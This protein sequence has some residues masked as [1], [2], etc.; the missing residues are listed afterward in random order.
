MPFKKHIRPGKIEASPDGDALVVHFTSEITHLDEDGMPINV[1]KMPDKREV[2]IGEAMRGLRE[3]DLPALAQEIVEKC[4]YIPES[5]TSQ[6]A[7]A[8]AQFPFDVVMWH[9]P[10]RR[11]KDKCDTR[12]VRQLEERAPAS[13]IV[14]PIRACTRVSTLCLGLTEKESTQATAEATTSRSMLPPGGKSTICLGMD[15]IQEVPKRETLAPPGGKSTICLGMDTAAA[16][17]SSNAFACGAHQNS[18]NVLTERP[19]TM[20]SAPPGGK[21]TLCLGMYTATEH[22]EPKAHEETETLG[23]RPA[24]GKSTFLRSCSSTGAETRPVGGK[25]HIV[26]GAEIL[27]LQDSANRVTAGG[28]SSICFGTDTSEWQVSSKALGQ[29]L[30]AAA[31]D[32]DVS[33]EK[34]A[35]AAV[36][37]AREM[38]PPE[39]VVSEDQ[40]EGEALAPASSRVPPGGLASVVLGTA[41]EWKIREDPTD[42]KLEVKQL[43]QDLPTPAR[44]IRAPPGGAATVLLG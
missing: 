35:L 3:E 15:N 12:C 5:K 31:P 38:D 23:S 4:R 28:N 14:T 2:P 40:P 43:K 25:D 20:L 6:V 18:G 24:A 44:S 11:V 30:E 17:V 13:F 26:L 19:T 27:E 42:T 9:V 16:P 10:S 32:C 7:K 22:C 37:P 8:V 36:S 33:E 41:S 1:E 39:A 34:D 29:P 21:S